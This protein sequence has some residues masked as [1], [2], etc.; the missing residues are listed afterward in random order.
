LSALS[1]RPSLFEPAA[2]VND[3]AVA[4]QIERRK[5]LRA[6]AFPISLALLFWFLLFSP[7]TDL[8]VMIHEE[9][10]WF[11]MTAATMTLGIWTLV[12]QRHKF[13]RLFAFEMR[14]VMW[15]LLHAVFLYGLSRLGVYLL[16]EIFSGVGPQLESIY[17]TRFQLDPAIIAVLLVLIIAPFEEIFWRGLILEEL[18]TVL[19]SRYALWIAIGLYSIVHIWA[20]NP[21]L[22]LA[23]FVLGAHWSL[24]YWKF[25]SLVPG[26]ISHAVWDVLIFVVFP[27]QL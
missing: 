10:F 6:L 17:A 21:M 12:R 16:T 13:T 3:A 7:W 27:V 25:K 5:S 22:L 15:G 20:M 23:A 8:S 1:S 2:D 24:L 18:Q 26:L 14:F 11:G 19:P 9:Y 4:L